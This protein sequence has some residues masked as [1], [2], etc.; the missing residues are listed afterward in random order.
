MPPLRVILTNVAD[1]IAVYTGR[2]TDPSTWAPDFGEALIDSLGEL[3]APALTGLET[4]ALAAAQGREA[5]A[6][7]K[8]EQG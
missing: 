6:T 8:M 3:L 4:T 7:A 2:V 1:A 5:E